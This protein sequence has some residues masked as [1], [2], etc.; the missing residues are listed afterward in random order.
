MLTNFMT[1][2]KLRLELLSI[3]QTF[4]SVFV[5]IFLLNLNSFDF[6]SISKETVIAFV[7]AVLRSALKATWNVLANKY[8]PT[9]STSPKA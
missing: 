2:D 5:P 6:T 8:L 4:F 1:S 9:L 3:A 7:I